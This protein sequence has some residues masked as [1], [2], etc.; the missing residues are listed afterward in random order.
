MF[1]ALL[2]PVKDK[3]KK[4]RVPNY[5]VMYEFLVFGVFD[6]RAA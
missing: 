3:P 5:Y 6:G 4:L 1:S 2:R